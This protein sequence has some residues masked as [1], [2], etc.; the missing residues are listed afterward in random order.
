MNYV[1]KNKQQD[2][3]IIHSMPDG[4]V[5]SIFTDEAQANGALRYYK[6][7]YKPGRFGMVMYRTEPSGQ[8]WTEDL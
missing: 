2:V 3:W 8:D 7:T 5:Q 6:E 1:P 4:S